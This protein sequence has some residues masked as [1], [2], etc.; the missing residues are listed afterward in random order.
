M[1]WERQQEKHRFLRARVSDYKAQK[2]RDDER[3]KKI[4]AM[5]DRSNA[6]RAFTREEIEKK[7]ES[8][9][10]HAKEKRRLKE[11]Q[12]REKVRVCM[13]CV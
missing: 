13:W 7:R 3:D 10:S 5:A 6:P 11:R 8:E 2:E 12:E 9:I 1:R 4:K